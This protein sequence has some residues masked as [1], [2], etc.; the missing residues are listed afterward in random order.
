MEVLYLILCQEMTQLQY[1][2]NWMI[3]EIL[4]VLQM[5]AQK[6]EE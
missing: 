1:K 2:W 3:V 6:V 5:A 4:H